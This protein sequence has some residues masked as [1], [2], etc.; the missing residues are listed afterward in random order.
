[1]E[2]GNTKQEILEAAL[3][4]FSIQ[5]FEATSVSQIADAVGIRKASLYSH[6]EN[7]QA[8]LD[9]LVQEVLK[10]YGE[11]SI[12]AR[13][14]WE[15]ATGD[16][17]QTSDAAVKMIQGQI[18]Y[19]LH[20]R[21]IS[22]ARKMLVIE[23]FRNSEIAKLQT[24]QNYT[25]VMHYFTGLVKYLIQDG[26]LIEDNPEIMAAQ[27]CLPISAWINLCDREPERESEVMELVEKHIRQF[28]RL[29]QTKAR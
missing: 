22:R 10:Q 19:I 24:K 7:K 20:D 26:V 5:G 15:K 28:F 2:K 9:A 18:R 3:D 23:Q 16:L 21:S 27:L 12:F 4:L 14:D 13:E 8:I 11:H 29:Y 6:F 17:P 25:D 1:M